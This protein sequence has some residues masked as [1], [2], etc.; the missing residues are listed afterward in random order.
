[1]SKE[2]FLKIQTCVLKVNIHCDGCKHKVKKILQKIDGVYT[3][4][5]DSEQGKVIVSGNID[6]AAI[7]KKLNKNGKHAELWSSPKPINNHQNQLNN[8]LKNLQIYNGKGGNNSVNKQQQQQ[9]GQKGCNNNHPKGGGGGGP[10]HPQQQ[11]QMK[12]LPDLKLPPHFLKDM[13]M[14]PALG[15]PNGKGQNGKPGGG[16]KPPPMDDG[17]S[18]DEFDDDDHEF[19]DDDDD[20]DDDDLDDDDDEFD[21]DDD[22]VDDI[23]H[24][25]KPKAGIMSGYGHG[26]PNMP[27][28][29]LMM[30]GFKEAGENQNQGGGKNGG[31]SGAP[32]M[33]G[34]MG[35]KGPHGMP[36]MTMNRNHHPAA[37]QGLPAMN[38][39][40][41]MGGQ[42]QQ[43]QQ[44]AAMMMNQQRANGNERFQPMMYA[45]PPPAVNYMPP[46]G[47]GHTPGYP[48]PPPPGYGHPPGY[49]YPPP[50]GERVDQ[51]TM[52]SDENT[53]SCTMM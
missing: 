31:G 24:P 14:P 25:N 7:I 12:G 22:E 3:M 15:P 9:P 46:P 49:P 53:S 27:P 38:G 23:I 51:Y 47:Y 5:I 19:D 1:M 32:N 40:G 10:P 4:K 44:L 26:G 33:N 21:D 18:D 43:Q 52:F 20:Y 34:F 29:A 39:P 41:P 37:V 30:N 6:P 13:K 17:L 50:P 42:Q 36:N 48:Y 28:N 8:Q 16:G 35:N 11:M 2:E 45:R